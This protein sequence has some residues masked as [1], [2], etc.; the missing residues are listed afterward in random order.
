MSLSKA[1]L[2]WAGYLVTVAAIVFV[3]LHI[4]DYFGQISRVA[5]GYR[6]WLVIVAGSIFYVLI[7]QFVALAWFVL[8]KSTGT[9]H[10]S[11]GVALRI[12]NKTQIYKYIPTN[13]MHMVGRFVLAQR[14]G[15]GQAALLY[16]QTTELV[17]M[18]SI[19]A[20]VA[21]VLAEPLAANL[22]Q[23]SGIDAG[24]AYWL[25]AAGGLAAAALAVLVLRRTSVQM[26]PHRTLRGIAASI[27][28]YVAF[29]AGN[30]LILLWLVSTSAGQQPA[31]VTIV[32][33]SA[34]GWVA[35]FV[36]PGAPGGLGVREAVY[37]A[38]LQFVGV[39]TSTAVAAALAHRVASVA[40]D[41]LAAGG[42]GFLP[43]K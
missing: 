12:F 23:A 27:A 37:L 31:W 30:G 11:L 1:F 7:L 35:G 2:R 41:C 17:L 18:A 25:L 28:L 34:A 33:I 39:P 10:L 26:D 21:V 19:A 20:V 5:Q 4:R 3:A 29:F 9:A 16:A 24:V 22:V 8:A 6:L 36:V 15:A 32:G 43:E 40:G 14:A 38:G 42:A 13:V